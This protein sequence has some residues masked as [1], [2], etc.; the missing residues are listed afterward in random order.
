LRSRAVVLLLAVSIILGAGFIIRGLPG[1]WSLT[2]EQKRLLV[3]GAQRSASPMS[4]RL[5]PPLFDSER[6]RLDRNRSSGLSSTAVDGNPQAHADQQRQQQVRVLFEHGANLLRQGELARARQALELL[7][8][9]APKLP[10]GYINLGFV[11]FE[12]GNTKASLRA[13][14]YATQLNRYQ[15]NGYYGAALAYE[16]LQDYEA[17]MGQM[18]SF[19]HLSQ[20]GNRFL[21]KARSA[22]WEWE[23]IIADK[24]QR[25]SVSEAVVSA[26]NR[27]P[28]GG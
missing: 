4:E 22:L 21:A 7:I 2:T 8:R 9:L 11:L 16:R 1:D 13:F 15:S 19:I 6:W 18:R 17:A 27:G 10:E 12:Q 3:A 28:E 20:A 14:N 25:S 5:P 24:Q 23:K 26:L